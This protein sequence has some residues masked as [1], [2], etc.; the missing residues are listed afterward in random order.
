MA[1]FQFSTQS[2]KIWLN[3]NWEGG[4]VY[5]WAVKTQSAKFWP[6]F[7]SGGGGGILGSQ[8]ENWYSCQFGQKFWKP[9]LPLHL[10]MWRLIMDRRMYLSLD[11][12]MLYQI[13]A[14]GLNIYEV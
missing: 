4:G 14:S 12:P 11:P 13:L 2:T 3:L 10:R 7:I 5:S 8:I 9:S 6:T 1:R